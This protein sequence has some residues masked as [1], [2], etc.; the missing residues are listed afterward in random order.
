MTDI[1]MDVKYR[2]LDRRDV[3]VYT[4]DGPNPHYPVICAVQAHDGEWMPSHRTKEGH[5]PYS[6]GGNLEPV[7]PDPVVVWAAQFE[8]ED[9]TIQTL[10]T[11]YDTEAQ[12]RAT[13][14][15]ATRYMKMQ[16]VRDV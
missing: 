4:V 9:G 7:P 12:V 14:P 3:I 15:K 16:E 1:K 2:T 13:Y 6:T 10:G 5:S 8:R 11:H